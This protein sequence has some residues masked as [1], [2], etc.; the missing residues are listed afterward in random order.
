MNQLFEALDAREKELDTVITKIKRNRR[1]VPEG[2]I[3]II[4]TRGRTQYYL[5]SEKDKR[6]GTYIRKK[7]EDIAYAIA[8]KEYDQRVLEHA[9]EEKQRIIKFRKSILPIQ[10][11]NIYP[12]INDARKPLIRP[13]RLT[14]DEYVSKWL[15]LQYE[16]LPFKENAPEFYSNKG[17]RMRSKSEVIIAN[18]LAAHNVP[19]LYECPVELEDLGIVYPDFRIL[20]VRKRKELF[21]EH[22]GLIDDREYRDDALVKIE[23]YHQSGFCQGDNFIYT[24]ETIRKP[25]NVKYV[26]L[27]IERY[28][29]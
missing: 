13:F 23:K 19:Y 21:W 3:R 7:D 6:V 27:L 15:S 24:M 12:S 11:E 29:L 26:E 18:A 17:E 4:S 25:L 28:C 16:G 5:L 10:I 1:K 8:Q 20:N 2:K 22:F 9:Q 14:D